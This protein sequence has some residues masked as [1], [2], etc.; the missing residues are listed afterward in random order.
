M[1]D[2]AGFSSGLRGSPGVGRLR[3][4]RARVPDI[5]S[6][7]ARMLV[8]TRKVGERIVIG[9]NVTVTVVLI[10][11]GFVR[12]GIDAPPEYPIVRRELLERAPPVVAPADGKDSSRK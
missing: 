8:M 4:V 9:D 6:G 3:S 2:R 11:G 7:R 1:S 10:G 5:H 12:V